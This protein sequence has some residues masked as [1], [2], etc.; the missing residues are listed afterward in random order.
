MDVIVQFEQIGEEI[1]YGVDGV[2]GS[3][4]SIINDGTGNEFISG[5]TISSP[6]SLSF[7][8]QADNGYEIE[9]WYVN[10]DVIQSGNISTFEYNA[11]VGQGA[12]I[13][14]RFARVPFNV[15][16]SGIN[17]VVTSAQVASGGTVRGGTQVTFTATANPGY[18]FDYFEVNGVKDITSTGTLTMTIEANTEV[19]A[20]FK[21]YANSQI[22]FSISG[23]GSISATKG[24]LLFNN[25][26]M[27][28]GNETIVFTAQPTR[29]SSDLIN[30]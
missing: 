4:T 6:T 8:A 22:N 17:G 20:H 21:P 28:A 5:N 23:N 10:G 9:A 14:V 29:R 11:L 25:G 7:T 3:I 2:G 13:K 26:E 30:Y 27:V 12:D 19:T 24:G 18:E 1:T 15:V 16:Y